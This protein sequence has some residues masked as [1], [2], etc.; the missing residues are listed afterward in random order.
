MT[1]RMPAGKDSGQLVRSIGIWGLAA[2]VFNGMV[3]AGIFALPGSVANHAGSW[4]PLVILGVGLAL[5]SV[6]LVFAAL[7]GLFEDT[8]GPILYVSEAF[9]PVA[10]FQTGWIQCLSTAAS[11]AANANLLADYVQRLAPASLADGPGHAGIVL[12][13]I[14]TA[15]AIN[16]LEARRS[17]A[18]IKRISIL[19]LLPLAL[20]FL[21]ALSTV[22]VGPA[23]LP[24]NEWS[25]SQAILLSVYA[26]TGFEGGLSVAGEARDP[27]R[28]FP[29]A[30]VGVFLLVVCLYAL[31]VWG[32]VATSY[33]PGE[34]DKAGLVTMATALAGAAGAAVIVITAV[35]SILGN[36]T[37]NTLSVSRRLLA[38]E[39]I[40]ALP[41]W[42]GAIRS[43]TG[44]PRNAVWFT[45]A[46]ITALAL[47]GGFA[48]LA[49]L[50]VAARLMVYLACIA[51]LPV[52][53]A[54]RGLPRTGGG[55]IIIAAALATCLLLISQSELKTWIGLALA[56]AAGFAI[57]FV[58]LRGV[59]GGVRTVD[60]S[61]KVD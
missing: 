5:L 12:A 60:P 29:R 47:S 20:L 33:A 49:V 37:V 58:A 35:L 53:R 40:P 46:A 48:A 26:F 50:S 3:G 24:A 31:I 6:V 22:G 32:Y 36:V 17:A 59:A 42:F 9:G 51:A 7:S 43:D 54:R 52:V 8:G 25:L 14:G 13:A 38:L 41:A 56:I 39:Q 30:L 57:R 23:L 4:A 19:K 18:W 44:L 21:L 55:W 27:R 1:A 34:P 10:A 15:L 11:A 28:D 16:L 45:V 2:V 61:A